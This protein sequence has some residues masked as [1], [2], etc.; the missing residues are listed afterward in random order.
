MVCATRQGRRFSASGNYLGDYEKFSCTFFAVA[1]FSAHSRADSITL[2]FIKSPKP[3]DWTSPRKL[4]FS[5]IRNLVAKVH[6]G[7]R[8]SIGHVYVELQCGNQHLLTGVTSDNDQE[9]RNALFLD[10]YG[11]G[12]LLRNSAGKFDD[13][14]EIAADLDSLQAS[15]RSNFISFS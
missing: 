15:G 1:F 14:D 5:A 10:G 7:K 13:L 6:G 11:L 12:V 3:T 4:A 2:H 9:E 8:H